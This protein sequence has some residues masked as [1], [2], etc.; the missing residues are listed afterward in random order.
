MAKF[1]ANPEDTQTLLA[2]ADEFYAGGQFETSATWLDKLLAIDPE[3]VQGLLARG[4][5]Y[6]N[7]VDLASAEST[8]KKVA[9][10]EPDNIEVH[11]D[12]GFVAGQASVLLVWLR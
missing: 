8:W 5:V 10:L 6:F 3:H 7:L 11:Y 4:A 1:Q 2:L 12:L 9:V